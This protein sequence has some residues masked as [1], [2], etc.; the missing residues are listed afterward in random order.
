MEFTV[1]KSALEPVLTR[2]L[3]AVDRS[4][5]S[6]SILENFFIKADGQ[7]LHFTATNLDVTLYEEFNHG[8]LA[9]AEQGTMCIPARKFYDIV[10]LL[11]DGPIK[12]TLAENGWAHIIAKGSKFKIPSPPSQ[13]FPELPSPA[14]V[15][16]LDAPASDIKAMIAA[17]Q[18]ATSSEEDPS[19][20][21]CCIKVEMNSNGLRLVATNRS[22]LAMAEMQLDALLPDDLDV[23]LPERGATELSR[24]VSGAETIGVAL[25][26]NALFF[27]AGTTILASRLTA[28]S[29]P[30]YELLLNAV[31]GRT[32]KVILKVDELSAAIKRAMLAAE[33]KVFTIAMRI[34]KTEV[35]LTAAS[36]G[37]GSAEEILPCD[38]NG[39]ELSI[40]INGKLM[41]EFLDHVE[42][43]V[44]LEVAS[45]SGQPLLCSCGDERRS[46]K[47][48]FM[49]I[50]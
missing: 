38:Y 45:G 2:L 42:G 36:A 8:Q 49:P 31:A 27:R 16:W 26:E 24:I 44:T 19:F 15:S 30:S 46:F 4:K 41:T 23:L 28:G 11:R 17:T 1:T 9:V 37:E 3:N 29:F 33:E 10:K 47:Y 14:G 21:L 18:F 39:E 48:I 35:Y 7:S 50:W 34:T 25:H 43:Q 6:L 13:S 32:S 22:R 5:K 40:N 20:S 12:V